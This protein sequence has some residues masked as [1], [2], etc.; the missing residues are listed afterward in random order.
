ML[1][2]IGLVVLVFSFVFVMGAG[3]AN[4]VTLTL[5]AGTAVSDGLLTLGNAAASVVTIGNAA[6]TAAITLGDS[7]ATLSEL[8]LGGGNGIHTINIGD[9]TAANAITVGGAASTT[10]VKGIL[11]VNGET[12]TGIGQFNLGSYSVPETLN[13]NP[14]AL[15]IGSTVNILHSAGAGDNDDLVGSYSKVAI[16]GAGDSGL[17][18]A[19]SASRAYVLAGVA[20]QVYGSQPWASHAG[21]GAVTAMSGLSAKV[22]VNA[23]NFTASTVNAGHFHIEGAATVTGQFD[24]VMI[25]AYPDVTSLDSGLAI[26][27]DSGA[28]VNTGIRITGAPVSEMTLSSGAKIFSGTAAT[29]AAVRAAVG[30][31]PPIGSLF[32]GN[33]AVATTKP[34]LYV[35]VLNAAGDTDWERVVTQASD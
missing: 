32:I 2:K 1:K 15:V 8:S 14:G 31:T 21:T 26:A 18:A 29:R 10:T 28:V 17:T 11:A 3:S 24:G 16:S 12:T 9:G 5:G 34:N 23:D 20:S 22:D 30:D 25:E 4:A 7:T 35:K 6:Q 27:V 33:A 13:T 19:A